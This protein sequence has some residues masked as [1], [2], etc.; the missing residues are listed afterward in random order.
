MPPPPVA[1]GRGIKACSRYQFRVSIR[2]WVIMFSGWE[3]GADHDQAKCSVPVYKAMNRPARSYK[4]E[5]ASVTA[6]LR[7]S[8]W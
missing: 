4:E 8:L 5:L 6:T 7:S 1:G 2:T 3:C